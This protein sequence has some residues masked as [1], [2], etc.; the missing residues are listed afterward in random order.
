[1]MVDLYLG[2]VILF[3]LHDDFR[4]CTIGACLTCLM[5]RLR[6]QGL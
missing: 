1:M 4:V 2:I 3:G 6:F 5:M